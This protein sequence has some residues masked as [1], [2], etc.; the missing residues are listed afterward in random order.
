MYVCEVLMCSL[1]WPHSE[2]TVTIPVKPGSTT[3]GFCYRRFMNNT[4]DM[5]GIIGESLSIIVVLN[6][7]I[8]KELL[9]VKYACLAIIE[10][11]VQGQ[12]EYETCEM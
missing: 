9:T 7:E 12:Q 1:L 6:G 5:Q 8:V 11:E 10:S 2:V 3:N 4:S